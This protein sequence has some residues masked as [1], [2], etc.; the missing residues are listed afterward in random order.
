MCEGV[1]GGRPSQIASLCS[2]IYWLLVL[3]FEMYLFKVLTR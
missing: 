1:G 2:V 3:V